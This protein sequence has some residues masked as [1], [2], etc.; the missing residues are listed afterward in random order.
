MGWLSIAIMGAIPFVI[1]AYI[2]P[3]EVAQ[4]YVPAVAEYQSSIFYFKNPLHAIFESMSGFTTTGLSMALHVPT[5]G[6][7]LYY[8][9]GHIFNYWGELVLLFCL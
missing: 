3:D 7:G 8:F 6:K 4:K 1:I 5:I 9:I 2:T